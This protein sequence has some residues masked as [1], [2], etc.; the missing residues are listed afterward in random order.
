MKIKQLNKKENF[1]YKSI[2]DKF[3]KTK[4]IEIIVSDYKHFM[5]KL[6]CLPFIYLYCINLI[7]I[8]HT[9]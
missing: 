3:K 9:F 8:F 2:S 4:I 5:K 6:F 7:N 1:I